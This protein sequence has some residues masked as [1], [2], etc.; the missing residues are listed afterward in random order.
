MVGL[1]ES[2][3]Q[4]E[5]FVPRNKVTVRVKHVGETGL[6]AHRAWPRAAAPRRGGARRRSCPPA[7]P[8]SSGT[9]AASPAY[10]RPATVRTSYIKY[11]TLLH[12]YIV[13]WKRSENFV[14]D[15]NGGRTCK[16]FQSL[17]TTY[18]RP[19]ILSMIQGR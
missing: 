4:K 8:A 5:G 16:L 18:V 10:P 17:F 13:L 6:I 7:R 1:E 14:K 15:C 3:S 11:Y 19:P 12:S 2:G 9:C